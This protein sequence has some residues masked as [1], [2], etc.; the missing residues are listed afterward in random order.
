MR[1]DILEKSY[2]PFQCLVINT[3]NHF[4]VAG[5]STA[6]YQVL[7]VL[8]AS[9]SRTTKELAAL[10]GISQSGASK[11]T[12]RLLDKGYIVQKR[13]D[14]DRRCYD[15]SIAPAGREFL[16]RAEKFR[17]EILVVI[18]NALSEQEAGAFAGLCG[19]IVAS[20]AHGR[21]KE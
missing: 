9:G 4:N 13:S 15:I 10:R 11:L 5:I 1:D 7:D 18:K 2:I 17:K 8:A 6:Q 12:K 21:E 16:N 3:L 20:A 19:K 14:I